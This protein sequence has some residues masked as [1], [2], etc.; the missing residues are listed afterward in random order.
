MKP[1]YALGNPSREFAAEQSPRLL[2][3]TMYAELEPPSRACTRPPRRHRSRLWC[4]LRDPGWNCQYWIR[5][6]SFTCQYR[7]DPR[8]PRPGFC[9][10][11]QKITDAPIHKPRHI[12]R[13]YAARPHRTT[14]RHPQYRVGWTST[15]GRYSGTPYNEEGGGGVD[16]PRPPLASTVAN[17]CN[18]PFLLIAS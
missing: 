17:T 15:Y 11:T 1:R 7:R 4:T 16:Q 10:L 8:S 5:S 13:D 6:R 2:T 12:V 14:T 3:C 9:S 18:S